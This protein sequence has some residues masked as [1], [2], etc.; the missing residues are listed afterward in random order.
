V[1]RTHANIIYKN[2]SYFIV[3]LNSTNGTFV[4]GQQLSANQEVRL[5]VNDRI[6]FADEE[7]IFR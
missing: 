5:N 1:S 4:N 7:F 6:K 3:D 2:G